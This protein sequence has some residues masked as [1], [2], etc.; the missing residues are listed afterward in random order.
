MTSEDDTYGRGYEEGYAEG[1]DG[2]RAAGYLQGWHEALN[3]FAADMATAAAQLEAAL[4]GDGAMPF[5]RGHHS[6]TVRGLKLAGKAALK[7]AGQ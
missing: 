5:Q 2:G 1:S 3:D 7:A 4:P 6:G